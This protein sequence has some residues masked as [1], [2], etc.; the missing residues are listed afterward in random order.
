MLPVYLI[1]G[2]GSEE[3]M[4]ELGRLLMWLH[5]ILVVMGCS[6]MDVAVQKG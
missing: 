3:E 2:G 6:M 1:I 5:Y 4:V